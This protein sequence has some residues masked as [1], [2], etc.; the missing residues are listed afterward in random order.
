LAAAICQAGIAALPDGIPALNGLPLRPW[1]DATASVPAALLTDAGLGAVLSL[2]WLLLLAVVLVLEVFADVLPL[3]ELVPGFRVKEVGVRVDVEGGFILWPISIFK[4]LSSALSSRSRL[5][6]LSFWPSMA[7]GMRSLSPRTSSLM[8][9]DS[10][11][12]LLL[13][14]FNS[15]MTVSTSVNA[16][17]NLSVRAC[18]DAFRASV[19]FESCSRRANAFSNDSSIACLSCSS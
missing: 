16:V 13:E 5:S 12:L 10:S 4:L 6:V 11:S 3:F 18:S 7:L 9:W 15:L 17:S 1:S 8:R 19:S 14:L 2:V